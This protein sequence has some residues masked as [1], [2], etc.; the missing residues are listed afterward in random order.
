MSHVTKLL[1]RMIM[2]TNRNKICP[3]VEE[4]QC[5]FVEGKGT[6]NIIYFLR[7]LAKRFIEVR[8]DHY[9]CCI[10]YT[11]AFDINIHEHLINL[12]KAFNT[13]GKDLSII[14]TSTAS[15]TLMTHYSLPQLRKKCRN[16]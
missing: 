15:N 12:L 9:L 13:N 14:K 5:S 4:E 1:L 7:T 3:E 16:Y 8:Q 11:K 10:D 2:M 6:R